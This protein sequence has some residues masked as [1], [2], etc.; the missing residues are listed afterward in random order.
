MQKECCLL[1]SVIPFKSHHLVH[2]IVHTKI[3]FLRTL[4]FRF[5]QPVEC[6]WFPVGLRV[7]EYVDDAGFVCD[8]Y[9][10]LDGSLDFLNGAAKVSSLAEH[11]H[12]LL[13]PNFAAESSGWSAVMTNA[14]YF[15]ML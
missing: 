2:V 10:F 4:Q 12:H 3:V 11:F 14:H 9:S 5:S 7:N 15:A 8:C 13:V 1:K 6:L